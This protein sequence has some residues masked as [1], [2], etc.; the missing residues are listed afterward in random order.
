MWPYPKADSQA[1]TTW[2]RGSGMRWGGKA[3][4][5][6]LQRITIVL[7]RSWVPCWGIQKLLRNYNCIGEITILKI[8]IIFKKWK[9]KKRIV[10]GCRV[11]CVRWSHLCVR[12]IALIAIQTDWRWSRLEALGSLLQ[13]SREEKMRAQ[14]KDKTEGGQRRGT[15][16]NSK[17]TGLSQKRKGSALSQRAFLI[18]RLQIKRSSSISWREQRARIRRL[19]PDSRVPKQV[20]ATQRQG[21]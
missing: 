12:K 9:K 3:G 20:M 21:S 7:L 10:S 13:M 5:A 2:S 16:T 15:L 11:A 4:R 6:T 14:A 17:N 8:V 19:W 18:G 1:W